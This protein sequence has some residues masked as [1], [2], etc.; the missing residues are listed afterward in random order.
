MNRTEKL[1]LTSFAIFL[2][3]LLGFM[4]CS[5]PHR[6]Q[7]PSLYKNRNFG[8]DTG[9]PFTPSGIAQLPKVF[10]VSDL[11]PL[12]ETHRILT[13]GKDKAY[14]NCQAAIDAA[15]PGDEVVIDARYV[16]SPIRLKNKGASDQFIIIR[17]ANLS[18]LPQ[19]GTRISRAD[20]ENMAVIETSVDDYAIYAEEQAHHYHLVGLEVRVNPAFTGTH[21]GLVSVGPW[22]LTPR[23]QIPRALVFS[24]SWIHGSPS[25]EVLNGVL[26]NG[27]E[28]SIVDSIIEDIHAHNERA[29]A[30]TGWKMGAGPFKVVNNEL[31]ASGGGLS[32]GGY[33]T[34]QDQIPSDVEFRK[35]HVHQRVEWRNSVTSLAGLKGP[36]RTGSLLSL[37]NAQRILIS[38]NIFENQ[39]AQSD[40]HN[41]GYAVEFYPD[42]LSNGTTGS[43]QAW[44]RVQDVTFVHNIIRNAA[45]AFNIVYQNF[46]VPAAI[47][48]RLEISNNLA[49]NI[50]TSW[51]NSLGLIL[52]RQEAQ[53]PVIFNH[54]TFLNVQGAGPQLLNP[55]SLGLYSQVTFTNNLCADEG[56][57]IKDS[58]HQTGEDTLRALFPGVLFSHNVLAGQNSA[59]YGDFSETNYFPATRSDIGFLADP[60]TGIT[61]YLTLQLSSQ[62]PYRGQASDGA[63]LG[64]DVLL[65]KS[66]MQ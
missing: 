26:L 61:D 48:Q 66:A 42:A 27:S 15:L 12:S 11:P 32:L 41:Y 31:L 30:I 51:G 54:N 39:W 16:C 58:N 25:Q 35:N 14:Q 4:N 7:D 47:A 46:E 19:Q 22:Y 38:G 60:T 44:V 55:W 24:R 6:S 57:G 52:L 9:N 62:S 33:T 53:G 18:Q 63:D 37:N 59:L 40:I 8:T 13:V 64:A 1:R 23:E 3:V 34:A 2:L 5:E 43:G 56:E 36:W 10:L 20:S 21:R 49:Y 45:G 29:V 17:T 65:I 50:G 28:V